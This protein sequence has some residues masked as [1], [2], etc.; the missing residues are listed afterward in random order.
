MTKEVTSIR[1]DE[2]VMEKVK[3]A[4][5]SQNRPI[6]NFIETILIKYFEDEEKEKPEPK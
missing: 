3:A 6:S 5:K 2:D 1:I 4:A